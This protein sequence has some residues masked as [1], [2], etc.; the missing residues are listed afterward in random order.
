MKIKH[1]ES[2]SSTVLPNR[3]SRDVP[4]R[5]LS[6]RESLPD[7]CRIPIPSARPGIHYPE[8]AVFRTWAFGYERSDDIKIE[9]VLQKEDLQVAV[10]SAFQW[11]M[12]WLFSKLN[13]EKSRLLFIMHAEGDDMIRRPATVSQLLMYA[14]DHRN[15]TSEKT[16]LKFRTSVSA[17]RQCLAASIVCTRSFSFSSTKITCEHWCPAP[18]SSISIGASPAAS[19][20]T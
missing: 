6:S 9:E 10:L 2:A 4:P 5:P 14:D 16:P 13:P 19:W 7:A 17:S 12:E 18:P 1:L 20:K 11:D 3:V 8:G 15:G